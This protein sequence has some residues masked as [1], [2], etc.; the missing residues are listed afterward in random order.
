MQLP[1]LYLKP[2]EE[3]RLLAGHLW[4]YSNEIDTKRSPL[5]KF[6]SGELVSV[7]TSNNRSLGIAYINPHTLLCARLLSTTEQPI[8][9]IF[10]EQRI[11]LALALREQCFNSPYYRLI[12]GESD[13]LPG[14]IVDRFGEDLVV[15]IATAG[16]ENLKSLIIAAL[17]SALNPK[18]ILLRNDI[19]WRELE[20]LNLDVQVAYGEPPQEVI[21]AEHDTKFCIP[22]QMGQ[23]TGWFYDQKSNRSRL[24]DYVHNKTVLD[25]FSYLGGWGIQAANFGAKQVYCV[26][27]S[28]LAINYIKRNAALNNLAACIDTIH[29]DA[30]AALK[31]LAL[32]KQKFAVIILDP[33][34]F[35]KKSKDLINGSNAYLRLHEMALRLLE[36]NGILFTCSCSM[37]LSRNALLDIIRKASINTEIPL[38]VIEQL[39]QAQDHPINPAIAE[40]EYLK[41][42]VININT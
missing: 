14:L 18:S 27:S 36:P 16:M 19:S 7:R 35:I 25:V 29:D 11:R 12:F 34:A 40:T 23:K 9:K 10:F 24:K 31:N 1:I 30:F 33:P 5:A 6:N 8:N 26:D 42:F 13:Y 38:K 4:I 32:Q 15:Q 17:L 28:E 20:G 22:L 39:H 21:I 41:G 3:R 37:H 2:R